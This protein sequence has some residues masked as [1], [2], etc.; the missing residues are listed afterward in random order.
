MGILRELT[1]FEGIGFWLIQ[2]KNEKMLIEISHFSRETWKSL[3]PTDFM[4]PAI[5]KKGK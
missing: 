2:T 3:D 4:P 1:Y 5:G